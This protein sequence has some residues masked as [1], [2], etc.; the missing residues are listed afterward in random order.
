MNSTPKITIIAALIAVLVLFSYAHAKPPPADLGYEPPDGWEFVMKLDSLA[1]HFLHC[2]NDTCYFSAAFSGSRETPFFHRLSTDGG[3]TWEDI[4]EIYPLNFKMN[5][6]ALHRMT[7]DMD[8]KQRY[9]EVSYDFYKT[10]DRYKA[11]NI[12]LGEKDLLESPI[13]TN[14]LISVHEGKQSTHMGYILHNTAAQISRNAGRNWEILELYRYPLGY[15]VYTFNFDWAEKGHWFYKSSDGY[16]DLDYER[17]PE[18]YFETFD[19]GKTFREIKFDPI[20]EFNSNLK[21]G[22]DGLKTITEKTKYFASGIN[23]QQ[24]DDT[25]KSNIFYDWLYLSDPNKPKSN[26]DSGYRRAITFL[27]NYYHQDNKNLNNHVVRIFENNG[28][29]L[30]SNYTIEHSLYHSTDNGQSWN[31]INDLGENPNFYDSF[32]DQSTKTLWIHVKDEPYLRGKN[33]AYYKGSLW[34]LKLPWG[35]SSVEDF[36]GDD[37]N[38]AIY[39][40][41]AMEYI[42]ITKPSEGFEPSEGSEVKIYNTLGECVNLTTYPSTGSGSGYLRIDVSHL[43][44]GVYY[45]RIGNQTQMFVK[46]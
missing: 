28:D 31:L 18:K 8:E 34:K 5:S 39:P 30:N 2:H 42:T 14:T 12:S 17:Q 23:I 41:P 27:D 32:L 3:E 40:N 29:I 44:R 24:Y 16:D 38:I 26:I 13:D 37:D 22:V 25:I 9:Y 1:A 36:K 6:N 7:V 46:M 43:P 19:N 21:I 20:S 45:L 10:S 11:I 33:H 15:T 4:K 35:A